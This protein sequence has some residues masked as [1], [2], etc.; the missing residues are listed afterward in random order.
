MAFTGQIDSP[1][2]FRQFL[3]LVNYADI[4]NGSTT[5]PNVFGKVPV[6]S[7]QGA[8]VTLTAQQSGSTVLFDRAAGIVYTLP[9]PSQALVGIYYDFITTV[10]ITSNN[11]T[12]ITDAGT[13]FVQGT[14]Y[15][16]KNDGTQLA[17]AGNGTSHIKVQSNGTTTGGVLGGQYRFTLI[18]PTVWQVL[19]AVQATGVIATPFA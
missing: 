5:I 2:L 15:V 12:V 14:I 10:T 13:T 9:A 1:Y 4:V 3:G 16:A 18:S 8:T 17:T 19:G 11:A 6:I 7:G